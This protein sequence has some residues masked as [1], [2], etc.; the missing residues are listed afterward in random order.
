MQFRFLLAG[1]FFLGFSFSLPAQ[2]VQRITQR[3]A[4]RRQANVPHGDD[5]IARAAAEME[6]KQFAAAHEDYRAA[7]TFL[8]E[9]GS[10]E[11]ANRR[12]LEGFCSSGVKLAEQRV[13]E[14][15]Y[16]EADQILNE[17]LSDRYNPR[18]S[19]ARE[20]LVHLREPGYIN[21]TVGPKFLGQI[22][23]VKRLL[24]EADGYFQSG[25]YDLAHK[26]YD[27]VLKIDPYNTA[28]RR[29]QERLDNAKYKYG[30][31]A[32]NE[33]RGRAMWE[34]EKGWERPVNQYGVQTDAVLSGQPLNISNTARINAKLSSIIIPHVEFRDAS[35]REALDFIG[36]QAASNDSTPEGKRGVDIILR[37]RTRG[38]AV[39][40]AQVP[41]QEPAAISPVPTTTAPVPEGAPSA[42]ATPIAK[43]IAAT[44]GPDV[45]RVTLTLNE[46]PLGEV[47]RYIAAQVGM[48]IKI[49]PYAVIVLP[50]NEGTDE[51]ITKRYHVPP[52]F[53][54]G[55]LDIGAY[56]GSANAA[57]NNAQSGD[58]EVTPPLVA[59]KVVERDEVPVPYRTSSSS[60]NVGA[61]TYNVRES[62]TQGS[63]GQTAEVK[64]RQ[65][66]TNDRQLVG[67][68]TAKQYLESMGVS[69][70]VFSDG[71]QAT[72]TFLP[73][74]GMLIVRNTQDNL[75]MIDALVE[76]ANASRPKQV[77]IESK[78]VE[79]NQNNLKELGFDWLLGKFGVFGD[80][81]QGAGGSS[82]TG[83]PVNQADYPFSTNGQFPVTSGNRSGTYAISANAIDALLMGTTGGAA[84]APGIFGLSGVFTDPQFQVVIRALNQKKGVDLLSAPRVTT[85]SGQRAVIEIVRE[86]RYP[87]IFTPPQVPSINGSGSGTTVS[88][89]T[90][91]PSTPGGFTTRNTGVTLEVEPIVGTDGTIDLNLVPQVV[92]FEGFINYGSPIFGINPNNISSTIVPQV[93]LTENVINQPI[94][95]TRKVNTSVSIYDGSTV[96]LGGLMREDVQKTEDRT[97]IIGDIPIVGR[98]FRTNAEQ[99]TKRNLVIFV[100]AHLVT[101]AGEL[102]HVEEDEV[103]PPE[104]PEVPMYKK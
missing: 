54:G 21:R 25:R 71:T 92:E 14:G 91:T 20:L 53:F 70:P 23:E 101:P 79:I 58:Q 15:R 5:L 33:T 59:G 24:T 63:A 103:I 65:Q 3:E 36:Q 57:T 100:T 76:Q 9:S 55:P 47:L 87:T 22:E 41:A 98:L 18:C 7:L 49:E 78:F 44:S 17:V 84:L 10:T 81:V 2:N 93:L 83:P 19:E 40:P 82:G 52:E 27:Q 73:Q 88:L 97:P 1:A 56:Y 12:A 29:G 77:E 67:R 13:A 104:L 60:L 89:S 69:F 37:D 62:S 72:A 31:E 74:S 51:L 11:R 34:V 95:S 96:V 80:R 50:L 64:L 45:G 48:R 102:A 90:V 16:D 26:R 35:I 85:K 4:A 43:R 28:A 75:D 61:N 68:A 30:K 32:Y 46:V 39:I 38:T 94:F 42:P 6:A 99:H 86:F 66:L 8:P